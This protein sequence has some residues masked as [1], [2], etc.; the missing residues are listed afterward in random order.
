[1]ACITYEVDVLA[2]AFGGCKCGYPKSDHKVSTDK[3]GR[4]P[5]KAAFVAVVKDATGAC[6][7]YNVD[8]LATAFGLCK[9]G[10]PKSDH[11]VNEEGPGRSSGKAL[12]VAIAKDATAACN[13]FDIDLLATEF[14]QCKCGC[15]K[16]E[17]DVKESGPGRTTGKAAFVAIAKEESGACESYAIDMLASAFGQC[18]CG[19]PKR[20]HPSPEEIA[21]KKNAAEEAAR[22]EEVA[23]RVRTEEEAARKRAEEAEAVQLRARAR[24]RAQQEAEEAARREAEELERMREAAAVQASRVAAAAAKK[25]QEAAAAVAAVAQAKAKA[26]AEEVERLRKVHRRAAEAQ[27]AAQAAEKEARGTAAKAAFAEEL[28]ATEKEHAASARK[29]VPA[30]ASASASTPTMPASVPAAVA[31]VEQSETEGRNKDQKHTAVPVEASTES[32]SSLSAKVTGNL[33]L[34]T[35]SDDALVQAGGVKDS[36]GHGL[37]Q[38]LPKQVTAGINKNGDSNEGEIRTTAS[39]KGS[40][41]T[42]MVLVAIIILSAALV[43]AFSAAKS[44]AEL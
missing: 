20:A 35:S 34:T 5:G 43:I 18:K 14:G 23:V 36:D 16:S 26:S 10:F 2:T 28:A 42:S 12:F 29:A 3:P 6:S 1:M 11:D 44:S 24:V 17:H 25:E 37:N 8:M 30:A 7:N 38:D 27:A 32:P 41:A 13:D 21:A 40:R 9:C 22:L 33:E 4:T 31:R 19:F 15:P 39:T